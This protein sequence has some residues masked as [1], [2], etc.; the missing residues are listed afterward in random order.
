MSQLRAVNSTWITRLCQGYASYVDIVN[1]FRT[2]LSLA[3]RRCATCPHP[4][5]VTNSSSP[6]T[7]RLATAPLFMLLFNLVIYVNLGSLPNSDV[8]SGHMRLSGIG[9]IGSQRNLAH[10]WGKK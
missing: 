10:K 4:S 3:G 6:R 8:A 2:L 1:K 9:A 5:R 7:E